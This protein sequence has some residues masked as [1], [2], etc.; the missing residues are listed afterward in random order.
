MALTEPQAQNTKEQHS[1][2]LGSCPLNSGVLALSYGAPNFSYNQKGREESNHASLCEG[3]EGK[4][5][6]GTEAE[7]P[8]H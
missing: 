2:C 1:N 3:V 6:S 7:A 5:P 8:C 4:E